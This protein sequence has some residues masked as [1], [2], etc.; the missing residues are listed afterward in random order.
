MVRLETRCQ[1]MEDFRISAMKAQEELERLRD[2]DDAEVIPSDE[3]DLDYVDN[4]EYQDEW[5]E[6]IQS[7]CPRSVSSSEY[8]DN[9]GDDEDDDDT[10]K[11]IG[12]M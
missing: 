9:N 3:D 1:N 12:A 10:N 2:T 5:D 4:D 6:D 11:H 7:V 8:I